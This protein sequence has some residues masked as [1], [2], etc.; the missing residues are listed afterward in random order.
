V[1]TR[2]LKPCKGCDKLSYIWARGKCKPCALKEKPPKKIQPVSEKKKQEIKTSNQYYRWAIDKN[3]IKNKGVCRCDECGEEIK[4][5]SGR[6]ICHIVSGGANKAL[7]LEPINHFIL[8]KG[9]TFGECS[10]G[11]KY[12][13]SGEKE[14]MNIYPRHVEVREI[15]NNKYYTGS[16]S[17]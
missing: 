16:M 11:W 7:Y 1:I 9:E 8:G 17:Q 3:I 10:C 13:E 6:N 5:P 15:L 12:D 2:K 14:K 4:S